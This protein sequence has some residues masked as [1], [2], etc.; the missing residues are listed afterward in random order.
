MVPTKLESAL[1]KAQPVSEGEED[2]KALV[3]ALDLKYESEEQL[4]T[5]NCG[6]F[7]NVEDADVAQSTNTV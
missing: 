6:N 1:A 5:K 7:R 3:A 2:A 4:N